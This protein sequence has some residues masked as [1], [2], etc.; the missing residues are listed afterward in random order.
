VIFVTGGTG[1]LGRALVPL[2]L[3]QGQDVR[4]LVRRPEAHPWLRDGDNLTII[5]GDL[6]DRAALA[7]GMAG[8]SAVIHCAGLFRL[9]GRPEHFVHTNVEGTRQVVDA[10]AS[11]G[12]SLLANY[13]AGLLPPFLMLFLAA[14]TG[15]TLPQLIGALTGR[16]RGRYT[17][18]AVAAGIVIG[19]IPTLLP[20]AQ[21]VLIGA[22]LAALLWPAL[23]NAVLFAVAY[24]WF[25]RGPSI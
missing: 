20:L 8:C 21:V 7:E 2:L 23:F 24:G 12:V 11:A 15:G 14:A 5:R 13:V 17:H 6:H 16:R 25:R 4:L 9:W 19:A 10:A 22:P 1:F 18:F 3:E